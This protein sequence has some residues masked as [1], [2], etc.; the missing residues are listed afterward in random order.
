MKS[1]KSV[2]V[3]VDDHHL[4]VGVDDF[5]CDYRWGEEEAIPA[6]FLAVLKERFQVE[7]YVALAER[8]NP[9]IVVELGIRRG[10][11]SALLH[12][13]HR[14][15]LLI[16]IELDSE[17]AAELSRYIA[18]HDLDD[19]IKAYYGVD[20]ADR[21][22]LS[23]I[24]TDE[25]RGRPV[26]LVVDDASHLLAPTRASFEVL[27]PLLREGGLYIIED[28]NWDHILAE[29]IAG[30]VSDSTHPKYE[31]VQRAIEANA[32]QIDE[33]KQSLVRLALELVLARASTHDAIREV[34]IMNNWLVVQRGS[35]LLDTLSFSL[36]DLAKDY[37][38]TLR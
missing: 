14:P 11:G 21:D 35:E 7:R 12:A 2:P 38:N 33:K 16:G 28:W 25:L 23:A 9:E 20:Q 13:L 1:T 30:V 3:F 37:S 17:P 32:S 22:A 4:R 10:G 26:D 36:A 8:F 5:Y 29:K 34:T 19:T 24:M 15:A 31:E 18:K 27:F 6:G